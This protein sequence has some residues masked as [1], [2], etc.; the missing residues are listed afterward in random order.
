MSSEASYYQSWSIDSLKLK[1]TRV[2]PP[3]CFLNLH[4]LDVNFWKIKIDFSISK[5]FAFE[6]VV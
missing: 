3:Q 5:D 1:G 2:V 6:V 4:Q